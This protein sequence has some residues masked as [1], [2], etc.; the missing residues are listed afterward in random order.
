MISY[1]Q[2]MSRAIGDYV[3]KCAQDKPAVEQARHPTLF[4]PK[5]TLITGK[6]YLMRIYAPTAGGD[7]AAGGAVGGA[8][9]R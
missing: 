1:P 8:G 6:T 9:A 7:R 4:P 5:T 2:A 3:Y